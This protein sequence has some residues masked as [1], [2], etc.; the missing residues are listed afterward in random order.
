MSGTVIRLG[1]GNYLLY[2]NERY[3]PHAKA[4]V[5]TPVRVRIYRINE[6]GRTMEYNDEDARDLLTQVYQFSRLNYKTV[7]QQNLPVTTLYPELAA[8]VVPFFEGKAIPE[9]AQHSLGFL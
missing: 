1:R 7:K 8:R 5:A 3:V 9:A 4:G 2:N 6:K